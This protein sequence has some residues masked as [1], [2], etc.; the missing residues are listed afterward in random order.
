VRVVEAARAN[1]REVQLYVFSDH[2]MANC[3]VHLDLMARVEALDLKMGRDYAVVYDSTMARFW[4]L[5]H[6]ARREI[7]ALLAGIS[8]GRVLPDSELQEL[9]TFFPD[10]HFGELIFL[11]RE[12]VLIVPSHMGARPIRAM[13]GYHPLEKHSYATL[14]TN[15]DDLPED[16]AAI[17]DIFKLMVRAAQQA[18]AENNRPPRAAVAELTSRGH[19]L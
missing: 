16:L 15:L 19:A 13:H 3:D 4:F 2:G 18:H 9:R 11:V 6:K 1:Y 5:N 8:E 17:P 10:R 7:P 12:G 14:F